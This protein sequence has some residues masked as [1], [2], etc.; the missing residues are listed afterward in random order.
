MFDNLT[1]VIEVSKDHLDTTATSG[2]EI[3]SFIVG[4]LLTVVHAE[5]EQAVKRAVSERCQAAGDPLIGNFGALAAKRLVRSI[6]ISDLSGILG[7]FDAN[8]KKT[9]QTSIQNARSASYYSNLESS[10]QAIAHEATSNATMSDVQTWFVEAKQVPLKF[11]EA[12][13]LTN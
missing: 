1:R 8:C 7:H 9:F 13:G 5:F 12:L 6:K 2:T 3:E 11:R 4:Y 10:R